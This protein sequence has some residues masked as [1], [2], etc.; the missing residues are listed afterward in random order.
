MTYSDHAGPLADH[1]HDDVSVN[2]A[3][4]S[5]PA[6][7]LPF[8]TMIDGPA[9]TLKTPSA[10]KRRS[11]VVAEA[12]YCLGDRAGAVA[13]DKKSLELDP[14]NDNAKKMIELMD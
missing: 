9:S 2:E 3:P 1:L 7:T 12:Y 11:I 13:N 6:R 8:S 10:R 14:K 4:T 5:S